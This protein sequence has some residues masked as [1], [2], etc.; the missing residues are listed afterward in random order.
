MKALCRGN[1]E[2]YVEIQPEGGKAN[3]FFAVLV[4]R[5]CDTRVTKD[6]ELRVG[7]IGI[8]HKVGIALQWS[9]PVQALAKFQ[10]WPL[11][12]VHVFA[13]VDLQ[14]GLGVVYDP[15]VIGI[16]PEGAILGF[17]T[18]VVGTG[19]TIFPGGC[20]L[21]HGPRSKNHDGGPPEGSNSRAHYFTSK[22]TV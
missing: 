21:R 6:H 3:F 2:I 19:L 1:S 20:S 7:W 16:R 9:E 5:G 22:A 17:D 18:G 10:Q 8:P 12:A 15:F 4:C 13:A 14:L 11:I